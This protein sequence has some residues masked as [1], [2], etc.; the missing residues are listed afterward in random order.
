MTQLSLYVWN[1]N[2]VLEFQVVDILN[3][4]LMAAC[5]YETLGLTDH[6]APKI[7]VIGF[8]GALKL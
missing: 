3:K 1:I 4:M 6:D 5:A 8:T 7:I 2:G